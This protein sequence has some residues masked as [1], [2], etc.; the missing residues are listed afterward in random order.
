MAVIELLFV[1]EGERIVSRPARRWPTGVVAHTPQLRPCAQPR[2]RQ[3]CACGI[4]VSR[5]VLR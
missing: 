1:E 5:L 4:D 3:K 2:A